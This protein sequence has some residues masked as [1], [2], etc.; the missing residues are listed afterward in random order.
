MR[1]EAKHLTLLL[2]LM[3]LLATPCQGQEGSSQGMHIPSEYAA[4]DGMIV[5]LIHIELIECPWCTN[6]IENLARD[7]INLRVGEPF[8]K[9]Q[10]QQSIDAL[11]LSKRFGAVIPEIERVE[12]GIK[13]TF[14]LTPYREIKDIQIHGEYPLFKSDVLKSMNVYP[15][16][17]L[18]PDSPAVLEKLIGDLYIKEGYRN[19][20]I[21]VT[22]GKDLKGGLVILDVS[23][24][25]GPYYFLD[26]LKIRGNHAIIYAEIKSR[27]NSWRSS[28][29]IRESGR[30]IE[31]EF[32]Q[33]I[34]D[35]LVLYW[36]RGYPECEIQESVNKNEATGEVKAE[37]NITEGPYYE[38][39]F[40]G[41][42]WFKSYTLKD[43]IPIFIKGNRRDKGIKN[44]IKE[45]KERY[46]KDGFLFTEIEIL[47][48]KVTIKD[49]KIRKLNLLIKEGPRTLVESIH[50]SG[51][52]YFS[53]EELINKIQTGKA[54]FYSRK[55]FNP[56]ILEKDLASIRELY[57]TRGYNEVSVSHELTWNK[58]KTGVSVLVKITEGVK[59]AVSSVRILG[60][61][62]IPEKKAFSILQLKEGK[63]FRS[64]VIKSDETALSGFISENGY[65]YVSVKTEVV[66]SKDN[67]E[68]A[69][70]YAVDEGQ[71]MTMGNIYYRGNFKTRTSVIKKELGIEPG[72]PFSLKTM[73]EG[74]KNIRNMEVFDSVQFKTFGIKE[75]KDRVTLLI[76]MEETEPYYVQAATGYASDRGLYGNTRVGD[77]NIFGLNKD[78]W[79]GGELSQIGYQGGLSITQQRIFDTPVTNTNALSYEKKA[80]FNQIFGTS[81]WTSSCNFLRV[82]KPHITTSLG[83]RYEWRDQFLKDRSFTIPPGD[84]DSYEPRGSLI[85][86]PFISYDTRDSFVRPKEGFYSSYSVDI[87]K[88]YQNS[89]DNFL[90]H[91]LNLRYYYSPF[92]R[93]TLA[94]LGRS[95]YIYT[96]GKKGQLPVDQLFY[97]GGTMD[98]RGYNENMLRYDTSGN[99][100]GGRLSLVGSME[101]R[102]EVSHNWETALFY[103]TGSVRKALVDAGSDI[104]RSS[105]GIG[106]R[107]V[108]P[109]GPMG[110]LYGY[111]IHPKEGESPGRFLFSLGYTF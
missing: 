95:G 91:Y 101:A 4:F 66:M 49:E 56:D 34:K 44:G 24:R 7:L 94:W 14:L 65:P 110:L 76:D 71:R 18:L 100:V 60:L 68:A 38:L 28:F 77:H 61:K 59:T 75:E 111:K 74:Q 11:M 36:Q 78:A 54:P 6:T 108:T 25:P 43:D 15:G 26:S 27:M 46:R 93:L 50:F 83:F 82:Y 98:V 97:L 41:N 48:E 72:Q 33:D 5:K 20:H 67:T 84:E 2:F 92:Q 30:F 79:I 63:P 16:D 22:A 85:T 102:I 47:E 109:I 19:P 73:L 37:V 90:K 13:V 104:F 23:I 64:D 70:T 9:K 103:D 35:L 52:S 12:E 96:Y 58:D 17:A 45:I 3:L 106:L 53:E 10:Y 39:S 32:T 51:N 1:P 105:V 29:F 107:Y 80:E 87:S 62:T 69:I 57:L 21:S 42:K 88:G 55:I 40:S 89:L 99:P 8:S 81:V 31:K 86:T